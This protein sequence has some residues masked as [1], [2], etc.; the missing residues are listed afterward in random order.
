LYLQQQSEVAART[1]FALASAKQNKELDAKNESENAKKNEREKKRKLALFP[2][3][4]ESNRKPGSRAQ[5]H[6]G[7][8][9]ARVLSKV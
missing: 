8:G 3:F 2:P 6:S 5:I 4:V 1:F 7:G 9:K